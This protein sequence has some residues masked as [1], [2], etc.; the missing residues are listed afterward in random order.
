VGAA[1]RRPR[2]GYCTGSSVGV[3]RGIAF[4]GAA[5]RSRHQGRA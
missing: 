1:W 2:F 3:W 5:L 4:W